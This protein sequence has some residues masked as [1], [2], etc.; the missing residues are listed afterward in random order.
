MSQPSQSLLQV[1]GLQHGYPGR[2]AV[3]NSLRLEL[4][5]GESLAIL[6]RSGSGKSTLLNLLAGIDR[7]ASGSIRL[8]GSELVGLDETELTLVRRRSIG[9]VYQFFNLVPGLTLS[10]N[11][12]LPL[13]LNGVAEPERGRRVAEMLQAVD[14]PGRGDAFPEEISGGEQQRVALARALA[15]RPALLLA[16]EPTGNLDAETGNRVLELLLAL[17]R[18]DGHGLLLVTHSRA[19]ASRADRRLVLEQGVLREAAEDELAW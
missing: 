1:S 13:E 3:L 2:P 5:A 16:D 9:F 11:I 17:G 6:G 12:A 10:E 8:Q 19:V 15:H 7:P 4:A 14:L 18:S